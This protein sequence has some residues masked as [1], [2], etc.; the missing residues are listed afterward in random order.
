MKNQDFI[1]WTIMFRPDNS[2]ILESKSI[3][4]ARA[5][6][7]L[8]LKSG[9]KYRIIDEGFAVGM[10][11]NDDYHIH[12]GKQSPLFEV[13]MKQEE[14]IDPDNKLIYTDDDRAI[15]PFIDTA[16]AELIVMMVVAYLMGYQA[17]Y[18][19]ATEKG[20]P[21]LGCTEIKKL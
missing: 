7:T 13:I 14:L 6:T 18:V 9:E 21:F 8:E 15:F 20:D 1:K 10:K 12:V 19:V 5:E 4:K 16:V 3:D 11:D 2:N 17:Y